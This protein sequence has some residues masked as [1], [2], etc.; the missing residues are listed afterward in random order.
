MDV[1]AEP[2]R[3]MSTEELMLLNCGAGEDPWESPMDS[4]GI[5]LVNHKGNWIF[6]ERTDAEAEAVAAILWPPD[7]KRWLIGKDPD[8]GKNWGLQEKR[9][10]EDEFV[11][12]HH[13]FNGYE[14][15]QNPGKSEGQGSLACCS[16][17]GHK[18]LDMNEQLNNI[19]M[20][21]PK[22]SLQLNPALLASKLFEIFLKRIHRENRN[23][24]V[25]S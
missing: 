9:V 14:L 17:W 13:W 11:G 2:E 22:F 12:W 25:G 1:R 10:R 16:L 3:R 21:D 20:T 19:D 18:E 15:L 6:I 23:A 8:G 24:K 4:R 7:A 5:K